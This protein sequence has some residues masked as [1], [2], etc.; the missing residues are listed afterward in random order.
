MEIFTPPRP[1]HIPPENLTDAQLAEAVGSLERKL[2]SVRLSLRGARTM[3]LV[4]LAVILAVGFVL[5]W[6]GPAPFLT[7]IFER[8]EPVTLPVLLAWWGAVIATALFVGIVSYRLF[9]HR[10]RMVRAWN[11]KV[12]EIERRLSHAQAEAARREGL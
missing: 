12:H 2:R 1:D 11:H 7:R 10:M 5:L 3:G 8:G 9:A 6:V 4:S